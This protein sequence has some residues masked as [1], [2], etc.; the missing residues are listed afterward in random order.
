MDVEAQKSTGGEAA[1]LKK[2]AVF[3]ASVYVNAK[4]MADARRKRLI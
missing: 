1:S 2:L 4:A 3:A